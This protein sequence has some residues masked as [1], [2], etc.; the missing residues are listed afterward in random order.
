[1]ARRNQDQALRAIFS[2]LLPAPRLL[3]LLSFRDGSGLAAVHRAAAEGDAPLLEALLGA[4]PQQL[5]SLD[6][7]RRLPLEVAAHLQA[8]TLQLLLRAQRER[9]PANEPGPS[10]PSSL[11]G[12]DCRTAVPGLGA[13]PLLVAA[14]RSGQY[15]AAEALLAHGAPVGAMPRQQAA[16]GAAQQEQ[17]AAALAELLPL[18]ALALGL[19]HE[20]PPP[21]LPP[22]PVL[23]EQILRIADGLI[24]GGA[25]VDAAAPT[26]STL[27]LAL[28]GSAALGFLCASVFDAPAGRQHAALCLLDF[29]L[30]A[31]ADPA[32]P[33]QGA[34]GRHALHHAVASLHDCRA[35]SPP[36]AAVLHRLLQAGAGIEATTA[37]A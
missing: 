34:N 20:A 9:S 21:G 1:M 33:Q 11:A 26:S 18:H 3:E 32:L 28:R 15:D 22:G 8:D 19:T 17:Q 14:L 25:A 35:L 37:F 4:D 12:P 2:R 6:S 13:V 5:H 23:P 24:R 7:Q 27:P 31:G 36:F 10:P 16:A 29:L 30:A